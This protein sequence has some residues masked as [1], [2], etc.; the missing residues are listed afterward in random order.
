MN[1][2]TLIASTPRLLGVVW[3]ITLLFCTFA[4]WLFLYLAQQ[5]APVPAGVLAGLLV[6]IGATLF[7]GTLELT[8]HYLRH[9]AVRLTLTGQLPAVGKRL[10]AVIDLPANAAAAWV[11][12]ELACVHV[13]YEKLGAH[14]TVT[15]EKDRWSEKRQ[16]SVRRSGR[17]RSAVVGFEI[18]DSLPASSAQANGKGASKRP[19]RDHFVWELRVEAS[20][21]NPQFRRTLGVRVLPSGSGGGSASLRGH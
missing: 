21:G 19:P 15:F 6:V 20:G 12:A 9:D 18:P 5:D 3:G 17:R 7:I 13:S 2:H 4:G 10:D 16:F 8:L 11:G 1:I 14:R